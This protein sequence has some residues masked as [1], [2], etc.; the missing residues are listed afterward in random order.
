LDGFSMLTQT[1]V[2]ISDLQ[3]FSCIV[4][5]LAFSIQNFSINDDLLMLLKTFFSSWYQ[6]IDT[7]Y[8][9]SSTLNTKYNNIIIDRL[10]IAISKLI[11]T[12]LL[13]D[14]FSKKSMSDR[15]FHDN[16]FTMKQTKIDYSRW[17]STPKIQSK[18][19]SQLKIPGTHNS[20][21]YGLT[22]NLSQIIYRNINFLWN[23]SADAAPANGQ[24][25][26]SKDK[27]YVGRIL[28]DYVIDTAL[29]MSIS[30]NQ[31]I[32]QQLD[33]GIRFFDLRIYY[34]TDGSFYIQHGLRGPELNNVLAQVRN[35]LDAHSTSGELVFL[36]I[37]HTNFGTDPKILPD[38]VATIIQNNLKPYL[39]MPANSVGVKNFDFQSLKDTAISSI[40]TTDSHG[41][42]PKV[43]VLNTDN[44]DDYY[45]KDTV[46]NTRG[47]ADS[48]RWEI[49]SNG[50]NNVKELIELEGQELEKNMKHM[51]Q[52]S[53]IQTP[54]IMDIIQNVVSHLSGHAPMMLLE[55]LA[56]K[57]NS[58]LQKFLTNHTTGT[59]N[60]I[61][62]DWYD[63]SSTVD[64]VHVI[65][66]LN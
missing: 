25:P 52:I 57:T 64:P 31:T 18:F 37:S 40:T 62:M 35:F 50:V 21:S 46:V 43:I 61:T 63:I 47:F 38:K 55:Q 54:Q 32:R 48:G 42:S 26:F 28:L 6:L 9:L 65:I 34:D 39:Y 41:T 27:I 8:H 14:A 7:P 24:L 19:I 17:M 60:L 51:Y 58:A 13:K 11:N 5:Q 33:D 12:T 29:R 56:S 15:T 1:T 20:G 53:W 45:Y 23:L 2:N 16:I 49:N 22:R 4:T 3:G 66:E 59:F 44:S 30:Q 10:N 36:S